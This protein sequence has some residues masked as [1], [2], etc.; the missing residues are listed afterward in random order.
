MFEEKYNKYKYKYF[1]LKELINQKGQGT[2]PFKV[3]IFGG[4][5]PDLY[6]QGFYEVGFHPTSNFGAGKDWHDPRFWSDLDNELKNMTFDVIMIDDGSGSWLS[7]KCM[8]P[9]ITLIITRLVKGGIFI[10][11]GPHARDNGD[12]ITNMIRKEIKRCDFNI[13]GRIG[14]GEVYDNKIYTLYSLDQGEILQKIDKSGINED[15]LPGSLD[16]QNFIIKN[17]N[18]KYVK[19]LNQVEFIKKRFLTILP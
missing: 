4:G 6:G 12:D 17:P 7:E 18:F 14:C 2:P 10:L 9:I 11:E 3:L 16:P 19:E 8:I 13:V 5:H 15:I 1:S